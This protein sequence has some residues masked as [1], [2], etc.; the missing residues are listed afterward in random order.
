[1][2]VSPL[3]LNIEQGQIEFPYKPMIRFSTPSI[4]SNGKTEGI[5]V[6]NYLAE[7]ILNDFRDIST[8]SKGTLMLLNSDG[9]WLSNQDRSF[10][11]GFM[12]DDRKNQTFKSIYPSEWNAFINKQNQVLSKNGLFTFHAVNLKGETWYIVSMVPRINSN[13]SYF[14]D[15]NLQITIDVL[16]KN[17][18]YFILILSISIVV[19]F[20]IYINRRTYSRIKYFAEFD[21]LTKVYNRRAGLTKLNTLIPLDDRRRFVISLCF[22]D[23]NGLKQVNDTLGHR[24]GDELLI[25]VVANI[26]SVIR[27]TDFVIRLG[28]DEFLIVFNGTDIEEAENVWTRIKMK[29]DVINE[30]ENHPYFI[31]VS[32]GIVSHHEKQISPVD[33]LIKLADQKMYE[34][35]S[36]MKQNFNVLK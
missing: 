32:H 2:Y 31:S 3:D 30:T 20:L 9:Y 18:F 13:F 21:S 8:N 27:E 23:V 19:A 28:G 35:K 11:F 12:F 36:I 4:E 1:M 6:L 29:Y 22:L 7:A 33:D 17:A 26:K 34:E 14:T 5:I 25:H 10:E 16:R 24:F 15:D